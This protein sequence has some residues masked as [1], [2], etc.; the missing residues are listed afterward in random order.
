MSLRARTSI[1]AS[2]VAAVQRPQKHCPVVDAKRSVRREPVTFKGLLRRIRA[3]KTPTGRDVVEC[4]RCVAL[5]S[6]GEVPEHLLRALRNL[7][8]SADTVSGA[9]LAAGVTALGVV[10]Q[11]EPEVRRVLGVLVRRCRR[12][13]LFG[14]LDNR[15]LSSAMLSLPKLQPSPEVRAALPLLVPLIVL[16]PVPDLHLLSSSLYGVRVFPNEAAARGVIR[17]VCGKLECVQ[18]QRPTSVDV[19]LAAYGLSTHTQCPETDKILRLLHPLVEVAEPLTPVAIGASLTGICRQGGHPARAILRALL[20]HIRAVRTSVTAHAAA[21]AFNGFKAQAPCP[22]TKT[23]LAYLAQNFAA[24]L[25]LPLSGLDV[26]E[27]LMG[28]GIHAATE[29]GSQI[30]RELAACM[31]KSQQLHLS[32]EFACMSL[33]G[34]RACREGDATRGVL[35]E[36][37][38]ALKRHH[39]GCDRAEP[40]SGSVVSM[41]LY[42]MRLQSCTHEVRRLL[43]VLLPSF[44]SAAFTASDIGPALAGLRMKNTCSEV[45]SLLRAIIPVLP[46]APMEAGGIGSALY[47]MQCQTDAAETRQVITYLYWQLRQ[48]RHPMPKHFFN[49]GLQGLLCLNRNDVHVEHVIRRMLNNAPF[50]PDSLSCSYLKLARAQLGCQVKQ[51]DVAQASSQDTM[52]VKISAS[53]RALRYLLQSAGVPG[54]RYNVLHKSGFEMDIVSADGTNVEVDSAELHYTSEGKRHFQRMRDELLSRDHNIRVLRVSSAGDLH[55][56]VC[57]VAAALGADPSQYAWRAAAK[58]SKRGWGWALTASQKM[59]MRQCKPFD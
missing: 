9:G 35:E 27:L 25:E 21:A 22:E 43:R 38:S 57:A 47:G 8:S 12:R 23:A 15:T 46:V 30:L 1:P 58:L 41:S 55:S 54:V 17:A 40:L 3:L 18:G 14:S 34:L 10:D 48:L 42:G 56:V 2:I 19:Q 29:A 31:R 59:V 4:F 11:T 51:P 37:T 32:P 28:I 6:G 52:C 20:P 36:V 7:V 33:Y 50:A 5:Q 26:P 53:E 49:A 39:S 45:R 13:K 44:R 16:Q 24:R